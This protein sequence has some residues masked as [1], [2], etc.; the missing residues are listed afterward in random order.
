MMKR[1]AKAEA[2]QM[3]TLHSAVAALVALAEDLSG[4]APESALPTPAGVK[5]DMS[6]SVV[7][8]ID[9]LR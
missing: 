5:M 6:Q 4:R 8:D 9:R 2:V 7:R 1:A 3:E